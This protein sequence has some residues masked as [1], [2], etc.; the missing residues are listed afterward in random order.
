MAFA[1]ASR[2]NLRVRWKGLF[3]SYS[4]IA[5]G[6]F[7]WL[8]PL[9]GQVSH[10]GA[11]FWVQSPSLFVSFTTLVSFAM[12]YALPLW[13]MPLALLVALYTVF[14][15]T[16]VCL[17]QKEEG[18]SLIFTLFLLYLP[19]LILFL[20]SLF[21]PMFLARVLIGSCVFMLILIARGSRFLPRLVAGAIWIGI[22]SLGMMSIYN[23]YFD[24]NFARPP[25]REAAHHLKEHFRPGE[26]VIHTSD[27]S[28]VGFLHYAPEL[29]NRFPTGD[30]DYESASTRGRSGRIAGVK[31]EPLP[32]IL[33]GRERIW[34]VML[35]DHNL[36][37]QFAIRQRLSAEC[38]KL[39]EETDIRGIKIYL[40]TM[41][42]GQERGG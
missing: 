37:F 40:C 6:Y 29:D 27:S 35:P 36:E 34:L 38:D 24:P 21:R 16:F 28:F 3:L 9:L 25:V 10:V 39:E 26:A 12:G 30:P 18:D 13:L 2:R 33:T 5:L 14:C 17:R 8:I 4:G 1:V 42:V 7:P 32:T 20:I 22:L 15:A 23:Y 31:P 11:G 19:I 41:P